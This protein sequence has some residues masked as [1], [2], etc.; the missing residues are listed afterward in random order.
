MS[1]QDMK[2][3]VQSL[4]NKDDD[5]DNSYQGRQ[6]LYQRVTD[7]YDDFMYMGGENDFLPTEEGAVIE[8]GKFQKAHGEYHKKLISSL[9]L[10]L[11]IFAII[12]T[13]TYGV[14]LKLNPY[15]KEGE[16]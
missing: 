8:A 10:Y 9:L 6:G 2:G 5:K 7:N 12:S 11:I 4:L 16:K 14:L 1:K 3:Y 13:L 15:L